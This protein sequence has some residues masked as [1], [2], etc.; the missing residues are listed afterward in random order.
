MTFGGFVP[1]TIHPL[2][3]LPVSQSLKKFRTAMF[4]LKKASD[5]RPEAWLDDV[6]DQFS[7]AKG[8]RKDQSF[9]FPQFKRF[10][11]S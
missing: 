11:T 9:F 8:E 5:S 2:G 3:K 1:G 6:T 10:P 4:V 7:R